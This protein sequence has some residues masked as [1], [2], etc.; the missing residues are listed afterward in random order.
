MLL[1][2]SKKIRKDKVLLGTPIGSSRSTIHLKTGKLIARTGP[3]MLSLAN[4]S[5]DK[6][7]H[8]TFKVLHTLS[9]SLPLTKYKL[10]YPVLTLNLAEIKLLQEI[11]LLKRILGL[12]DPLP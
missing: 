3:S 7:E 12:M 8:D 9:Q 10:F 5:K 2:Q 4:L 1:K 11:M 6:E